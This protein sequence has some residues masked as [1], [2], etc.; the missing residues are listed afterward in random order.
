MSS[1]LWT[2]GEYIEAYPLPCDQEVEEYLY[3]TLRASGGKPMHLKWAWIVNPGTDILA[4][5]LCRVNGKYMIRYP[6][7]CDIG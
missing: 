6:S 3:Y 5:T 7:C 4:A 2:V 1:N